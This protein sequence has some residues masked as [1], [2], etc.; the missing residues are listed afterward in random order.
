MVGEISALTAAFI[1][2]VSSIVYDKIIAKTKASATLISFYRGF[3]SLPFFV[4]SLLILEPTLPQLSS[5]QWWYLSL[6]AIL[7]ITI[8]DTALFLSFQ[9]VGVRKA[10][11]LQTLTPLFGAFFAWIFLNESL[12]AYGLMGIPL[13]LLGIVWVIS[14]RAAAGRSPH[15]WRGIIWGLISTSSQGLGAIFV[16]EMLDNGDISP[17]WS[18]TFRMAL[19]TIILGIWLIYKGSMTFNLLSARQWQGIASASFGGSFVGLWLHQTAFQFAPVGIAATLLGTSPL[20]AVG[21]SLYLREKVTWRSL[22]G[23]MLALMGIGLLLIRQ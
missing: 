17:L 16:R 10:L 6:S 13:T 11:L 19:G 7:G 14:E 12:S 22:G 18:S 23:V 21:I 5:L 2:S 3:F 9:D 20:F 4:V 1:W 15:L 8:G